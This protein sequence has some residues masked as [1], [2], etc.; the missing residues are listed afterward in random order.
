VSLFTEYVGDKFRIEV[1]PDEFAE[2]TLIEA[3][4]SKN[5]AHSNTLPARQPFSLLFDVHGGAELPQQSYRL[6]HDQLGELFLF[7]V[8]VGRGQMESIFN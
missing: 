5:G 6:S 8:P 1:G 3:E 4:A 7:L 2:S